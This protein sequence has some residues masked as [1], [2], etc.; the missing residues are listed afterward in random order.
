MTCL[1]VFRLLE[2][3]RSES[4]QLTVDQFHKIDLEEEMDPPSFT[5]GKRK[6]KLARVC[7]ILC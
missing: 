2:F 1:S 3:E 4:S 7:F 5:E 6:T